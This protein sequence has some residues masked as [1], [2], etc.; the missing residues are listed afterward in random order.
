MRLGPHPQALSRGPFGPRSG[1]R[2][3]CP[4]LLS[5]SPDSYD[6]TV[7]AALQNSTHFLVSFTASEPSGMLYSS[8]IEAGNFHLFFLTSWRISLIGVLAGAPRQVQ[9]AVRRRGSILE[10]EARDPRVMLLEEL[11]RRAADVAG[12][13]P[14]PE[15]DVR[16]VAL[17]QRE[18]PIERGHAAL[19]VSVIRRVDLLLLREVADPLELRLVG[20][21]LERR[22][23]ARRGLRRR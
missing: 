21:Q 20:R 22:V 7:S 5:P 12:R 13:H 16:H 8:S 11:H 2:R 23:R 17:R 18:R 1:R 9:R 4:C 6:F 15:V 3:C 10:V 19:R 14:V